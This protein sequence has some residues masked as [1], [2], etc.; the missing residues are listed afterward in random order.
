M[1]T[2]AWVFTYFD[3]WLKWIHF[4]GLGVEPIRLLN[5]EK[6]KVECVINIGADLTRAVVLIFMLVIPITILPVI[7]PYT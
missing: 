1:T 6:V 2:S 4:E 3:F 5:W 7:G